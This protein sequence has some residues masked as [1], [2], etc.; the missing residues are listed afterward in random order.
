MR[1]LPQVELVS[2]SK[3]TEAQRDEMSQLAQEYRQEHPGLLENWSQELECVHRFVVVDTLSGRCVGLVSWTGAPG[4]AVPAWWIRDK[5]KGYGSA[6]IDRLVIEMQNRGV[7]GVGPIPIDAGIY[8]D[9][10]IKLAQ[11]LRKTYP[12]MFETRKPSPTPNLPERLRSR[13]RR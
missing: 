13:F 2:I 9:A 10:S 1:E 3:L 6:A 7:T 12:A 11:R 8:G 4:M 5:G